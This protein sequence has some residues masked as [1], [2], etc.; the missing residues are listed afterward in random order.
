MIRIIQAQEP[1][2]L[3]VGEKHPQLLFPVATY[4]D[5]MVS[6]FF[7]FPF[8]TYLF[9]I[10]QILKCNILVPSAILVHIV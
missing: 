1:R 10:Y 8:D 4:I 9:V 3:S 6:L 5:K 2:P 7:I